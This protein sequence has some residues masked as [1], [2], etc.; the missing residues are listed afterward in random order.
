MSSNYI[1][2][3]N[4]L[5]SV[6][7]IESMKQ[8]LAS[9]ERSYKSSYSKIQRSDRLIYH[10]Q[11]S[12]AGLGLTALNLKMGD[13]ALTSNPPYIRVPYNSTLQKISWSLNHGSL[14]DPGV[15]TLKFYRVGVVSPE[16]QVPVYLKA[17]NGAI[18]DNS[19]TL[20]EN[21]EISL[22]EGE[23][24]YPTLTGPAVDAMTALF[25]F[26]FLIEE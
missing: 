13:V 11:N 4:N 15:W 12:D 1:T 2:S 18:N 8:Y 22:T 5:S 3:V 21:E 7:D 16:L 26:F 17:V 19:Y 14:A 23:F 10:L 24:W 25:S 20:F 6:Q 9:L